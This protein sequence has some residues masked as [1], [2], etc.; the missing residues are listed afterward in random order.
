MKRWCLRITAGLL[1]ASGVPVAFAQTTTKE[2]GLIADWAPSVSKVQ[3]TT[4]TDGTGALNATV[5]GKPVQV[6]IG[7]G[8]G[9]K[10][11]GASSWLV[12]KDNIGA[13]RAGLPTRDLTVAAWVNLAATTEYGSI[14]GAMQD[15]GDFEK[16]WCL[17]YSG[18]SFYVAVSS[19]GAD[20][21]DGKLTYLKGAT[22]ISLGKWYNVVGTY[23]GVTMRLFVN[24]KLDAESKEQSG[25]ILYPAKAAYT[26]GAYVDDDEKHVMDGAIADL[27]VY[28]RAL[29]N[30]AIAQQYAAGLALASWEPPRTARRSRH[31]TV[32]MGPT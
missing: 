9:T 23:D 15:N 11:D 18:D 5:V 13:D 26:I 24:G 21:G 12:V 22:K 19:K 6:K 2:P 30:D 20:D 28:S 4:V 8:E 17:G 29:S 31:R 27:K 14:T 3:G 25:D 16:G 10:F 32:A 7:P 1:F